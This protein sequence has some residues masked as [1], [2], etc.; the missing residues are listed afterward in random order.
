MSLNTLAKCRFIVFF[1]ALVT[2]HFLGGCASM[3]PPGAP[4]P[5]PFAQSPLNALPVLN[6][7]D[8]F[9]SFNRKVTFFN[10]D[11]DRIALKPVAKAYQEI[12]PPIVRTGVSN[13]FNNYWDL[14]S[15]GN[16]FLQL[17]PAAGFDN[18]LR[19][20]FNTAFGFWGIFDI[21]GE[22][23]IERHRKDL[24]QTLARWGVRSGPYLVL[25]LFGP[26]TMR[27]AAII[28]FESRGEAI[29]T[30]DSS[31]KRNF[32]YTLRAVEKRANLLRASAALDDAALDKYTFTRDV[33]LQL[34]NNE[35]WDGNP[36]E[37]K[38]KE[39]SAPPDPTPS[40]PDQPVKKST[41]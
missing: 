38:D 34:R 1:L 15:A 25:P 7:V 37:I 18:L 32:L 26:T 9:E 6:L 28:P 22:A 30:F 4:N 16:A 40:A 10:D 23:G 19:F 29:R 31:D 35:I 2:V 8:P 3:A 14:W 11:L 5:P 17:E 20:G 21:A 24:G 39:S 41:P 27:D 13:F 12:T 36:P 33:F